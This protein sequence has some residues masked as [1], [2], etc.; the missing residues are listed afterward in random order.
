MPKQWT[1][2]QILEL[3]RSFQPVAVLAAAADLDPVGRRIFDAGFSA[4][5]QRRGGRGGGGVAV[6][7]S[8]GQAC[9]G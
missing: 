3:T 2:D 5:A 1:A 9:L 6:A 8:S 7:P 4:V